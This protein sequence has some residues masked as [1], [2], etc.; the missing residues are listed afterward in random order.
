MWDK[1]TAAR[2]A[3]VLVTGCGMGA[4]SCH[5]LK[6]WNASLGVMVGPDLVGTELHHPLLF[7][8]LWLCQE[9]QAL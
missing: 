9:P 8:R 4:C 3:C 2:Q 1:S 7:M 6:G 5:L